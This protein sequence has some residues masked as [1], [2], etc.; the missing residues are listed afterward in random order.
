MKRLHQRTRMFKTT[1]NR[2]LLK[3]DQPHSFQKP[4]APGTRETSPGLERRHTFINTSYRFSRV[5]VR[6]PV[7]D[8]YSVSCL[9]FLAHAHRG[10]VPTLPLSL[11]LSY[12][13]QKPSSFQSCFPTPFG[14]KAA[15]FGF[16]DESVK[17]TIFLS[18]TAR[19]VPT[20]LHA[21]RLRHCTHDVRQVSL[22]TYLDIFCMMFIQSH[23]TIYRMAYIV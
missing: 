6:T 4:H 9:R 13:I 1:L 23:H 8:P 16:S 15:R 3:T 12:A 21:R 5:S 18:K 7:L 19:T 22:R 2:K 20:S 17:Q 14:R 10:S 11:P